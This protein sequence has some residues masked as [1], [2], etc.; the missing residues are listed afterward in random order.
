MRFPVTMVVLTI[1]LQTFGSIFVITN[2]YGLGWI[3]AGAL[4]IFTLLTIPV[5]HAFW[6]WDGSKR[7]EEFNI[8]LEHLTVVGGFMLAAILTL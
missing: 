4:A 2:W 5:A 8:A 1:I 7:V 3:A 6:K